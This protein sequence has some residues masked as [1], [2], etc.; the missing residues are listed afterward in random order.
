MALGASSSS[1]ARQ[2]HG[3]EGGDPIADALRMATAGEYEAASQALLESGDHGLA[4]LTAVA[5][6]GRENK[7]EFLSTL[8]V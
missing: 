4:V 6:E 5:G 1:G 7:T 2:Q 3:S 8:R